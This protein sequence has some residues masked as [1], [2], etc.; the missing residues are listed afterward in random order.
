MTRWLDKR[1]WGNNEPA[2]G[3]TLTWDA[4]TGKII[5][6]SPPAGGGSTPTGTGFRHVTGGVEDPTAKLVADADVAVGA[7]IAESK[8]ALNYP[9]HAE[10]HQARHQSGGADALSGNVDANARV[11][12]RKNSGANVG[13]RRRL[14]FIEGANVTLTVADDAANEEVQVTIA[15]AGGGG[16]GSGKRI[17]DTDGNTY[18]DTELNAN[19]DKVRVGVGGTERGLFQTISP[20]LFISGDAQVTGT[21]GVSTLPTSNKLVD[22]GGG[23]T[24]TATMGVHIGLGASAAV[25]AGQVIGIGGYALAKT[26]G[27]T[28]AKGLNFTAGTLGVSLTEVAACVT[29]LLIQGSTVTNGKFFATGSVALLAGSLTNVYGFY[30]AMINGGT[31]R[32]P[33]YDAGTP[34]SENTRGNVFKSNTQLFGDPSWGGGAGVLGITNAT[35]VPTTNPTGGGILYASGGAL[36]WRGSSGTVTQIAPA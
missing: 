14:N 21:L 34:A 32:Y 11:A 10:N 12:V 5:W 23:N 29:G 31:N 33:F 3:K 9:T 28:T 22:V 6:K 18:V 27:D 15:A 2:D 19:E 36:Y 13:T 25:G 7:A 30:A 17:Q 20:H 26:A 4:A 35:T 1:Y 8:L 24:Y 16:G